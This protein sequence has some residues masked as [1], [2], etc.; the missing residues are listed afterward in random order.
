[1]EQSRDFPRGMQQELWLPILDL[2]CHDN[3]AQHRDLPFSLRQMFDAGNEILCAGMGGGFYRS[4]TPHNQTYQSFEHPNYNMYPQYSS[5]LYPVTPQ[6]VPNPIMGQPLSYPLS[7]QGP[8]QSNALPTY[9]F[10][11]AT[12]YQQPVSQPLP[13]AVTVQPGQPV[14]YNPS[15]VVK[16]EDLTMMFDKFAKMMVTALQQGQRFALTILSSTSNQDY[17]KNACNGV[18]KSGTMLLIARELTDLSRR[19]SVEEVQK[20]E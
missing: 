20:G 8:Y 5:A 14:F 12:S 4:T 16:S 15:P 6:L 13:Q 1:M 11:Q 17:L 18:E 10:P 9:L 2:L 3:R 19:V 7:Q